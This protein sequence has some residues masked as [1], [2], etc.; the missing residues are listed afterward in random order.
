MA[1]N[2]AF[3]APP[4]ASASTYP[5]RRIAPIPSGV[6]AWKG[7]ILTGKKQTARS[8]GA[9]Q[10]CNP[11]NRRFDRI[12][13]TP[14]VHPG[15]E[16][17]SCGLLDGLMGRA[18]LPQTDRVMG[19]DEDRRHLD[20]RRHA[21]RIPSVVR[22]YQEGSP[23]GTDAPVQQHA[24]HD[25]AHAEFA[26]SVVNIV[27]GPIPAHRTGLRPQCQIGTSEIGRTPNE[28]RQNRRERLDGV[29]RSL[30]GG[31]GLGL[32]VRLRDERGGVIFPV[33]WQ[34]VFDATLELRSKLR[35]SRLVAGEP[36]V[37]RGFESA[38]F[39]ARVPALVN[40]RWNLK[41][42]VIPADVHA[43]GG[44]LRL[45]K[46]RSM[47]VVT[48]GLVR[49]SLTDDGLA[50]D[51]AR[52]CKLRLRLLQ[53]GFHCLGAVTVHI[54][55][56][57]PAVCFESF[58]RVIGEPA[59]HVAV[60]GDAVIVVEDNHL[61]QSEGARQRAHLVGNAFHQAAVAERRRRCGDSRSRSRDD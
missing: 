13:R 59:F 7:K 44:D 49:R 2:T 32:L 15:N 53:R 54:R 18:V 1:I 43:R 39:R 9:F 52:S 61:S 34:F 29:L 26:H 17:Q 28:L 21:Q 20:E 55:H 41:R 56:H 42:G 47:R 10:G 46:R 58:R 16:A 6:R 50:T 35:V 22:K 3:G 31:D 23:V 27:S 57:M 48:S 45:A 36:T 12:A 40:I 25:R 24:V 14:D 51:Q 30:A 37:P 33:R 38:A 60:D 4:S 5:P 19:E 8:A 11:R